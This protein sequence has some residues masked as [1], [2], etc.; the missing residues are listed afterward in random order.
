MNNPESNNKESK[1]ELETGSPFVKGILVPALVSIIVAI[2]TTL[3]TIYIQNIFDR[4]NINILGAMPI[5]LY[6]PLLGPDDSK[7]RSHKLALIVKVDNSSPTP[8]MVHMALVEGC[9]RIPPL[10]A[11]SHLPKNMQLGSGTNIN[12]LN[13]RHKK[14]IQRIS[15]SAII[16]QDSQA[17]AAHGISYV[18]C[19][20]PFAGQPAYFTIPGS[21]S[22]KGDCKEI[23]VANPHPSISQVLNIKRIHYDLPN[24]VIDELKNGNLS[25]T[26][27]I[28]SEQ[29]TISP[30]LI[31]PLKSL[32]IKRWEDLALAQMYENPDTNFPPLKKYD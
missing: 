29:I 8:T 23:K 21:V 25:I 2:I 5:H 30:N 13:E 22:L 26:V 9:V 27:F 3:I 4:P 24:G 10:V 15:G 28:G 6:G 18:G 11:E 32:K 17:V 7:F 16:R 20:F 1:D 31:K 14:S 19:I 12:K